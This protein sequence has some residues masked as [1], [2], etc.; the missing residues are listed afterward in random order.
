[1][2]SRRAFLKA[3]LVLTPIAAGLAACGRGG[4]WPEGMVPIVWDRD[5]CVRCRM[6]IS[7]RRFAVEMRG[8]AQDAAFKFDDIG[9]A[10]FWQRDKAADHPWM[11]DAA[12]RIWVADVGSRG[13]EVHWLD[14]HGAQYIGKT[15]PMGYGFGAV[16]QPQPGS[17]D[18]ETMRQ[19]VLAR[20]K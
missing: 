12:T 2:M 11:A 13:N 19:H 15:S 16:G 1:M 9:C 14:A 20:G 10:I 18:Y 6:V 5:T 8:S 17:F 4:S 3:G 7:E